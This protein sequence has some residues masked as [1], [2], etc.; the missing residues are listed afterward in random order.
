MLSNTIGLMKEIALESKLTLVPFA[1]IYWTNV[2]TTTES[3]VPE[4]S[5][6]ESES[7]DY[8]GGAFGLMVEL[9]PKVNIAG[10]IEFSFESSDV[11][12]IIGLSFQ[13]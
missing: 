1:G 7:Y 8:W 3:K 13:P 4:F 2:W 10:T 9:S 12:Y 5:L 6:N 11:V